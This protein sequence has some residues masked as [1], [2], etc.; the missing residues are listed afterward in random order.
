MGNATGRS[1]KRSIGNFDGNIEELAALMRA[2]WRENQEQALDYD[3][4]F[5]RSAF[6]YPGCTP[7]LFPAIYHEGNLVA[8]IAG[9]PRAVRLAGQPLTLVNVSFLTVAPKYKRAGFGPLLWRELL[10]RARALGFEGA[11]NFCVDGDDMNRQML[12]IAQFC[13]QPTRQVF[14]VSYM[15]GLP[16][17]ATSG[18]NVEVLAGMETDIFLEAA[19]RIDDR[20]SLARVWTP[21]EA[22]W[23]CRGRSGAL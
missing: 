7:D 23:Q 8:F 16:P 11:I 21:A 10:Q 5:L 18:L 13:G 4:D 1:G 22:E 6:E 14:S 15:A 3:A 19:A 12:A 17:A 2:S 20:V 9:A